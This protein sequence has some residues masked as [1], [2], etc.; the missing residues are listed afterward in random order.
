MQCAMGRDTGVDEEDWQAFSPTTK[1]VEQIP[2][3][4]A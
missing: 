4:E 3:N 2:T 1:Y